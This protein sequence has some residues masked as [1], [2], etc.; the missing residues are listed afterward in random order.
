M[1]PFLPIFRY[2]NV[3]EKRKASALTFTT[4]LTLKFLEYDDSLDKQEIIAQAMPSAEVIALL[5]S[6]QGSLHSDLHRWSAPK[7]Y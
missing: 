1:K 6:G 7:R 4:P 2:V 3:F 5:F